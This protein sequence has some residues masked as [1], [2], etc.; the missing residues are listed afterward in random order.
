MGWGANA[1][2]D[3]AIEASQRRLRRRSLGD[4]PPRPCILWLHKRALCTRRMNRCR[5]RLQL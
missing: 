1:S 3:I 2:D 5:T 4:L